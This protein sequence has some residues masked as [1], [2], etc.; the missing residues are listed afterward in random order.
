MGL[1]EVARISLPEHA[2]EGGFDHAAVDTRASRLYVAHTSNNALDIVDLERRQFLRS[3]PS[4]PGV[5]GVW[6]DED[7]SLL[8]TSNRGEDTASIFRLPEET[9]LFR[10]RTGSR[11]NGLAFDP[12][13]G[14]LMVAGVGNPK[15]SDTPP[16]LTFVDATVGTAIGRIRAPGRTRWAIF[17]EASDS[18]YV[19]IADPSS[20]AV[21]LAQDPTRVD[22]LIP[23]PSKGPH[24]LEQDPS[25]DLL[26]CACDEGVLVTVEVPEGRV[27][28][29]GALAGPPDV[30]WLN[31][32]KRHLYCAAED[33]GMIHVFELETCRSLETVRTAPG[34]G[35]LTVD[36]ARGE[37][38]SF[39]PGSHED[40]VL[41][42]S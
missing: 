15:G 12:G 2:P 11:P 38:H 7:R 28:R 23:I 36:T 35:T 40:L 31:P 33:P 13:R 30:L 34:A 27:E 25:G 21:V 39:L 16:T 9:E 14:I 29:V 32:E 3:I 24:G 10:A 4:L 22:H 42:D 20:I 18:F 17:H 26:Y 8:F 5:A 41:R 37:V 19:N 6:V 1:I